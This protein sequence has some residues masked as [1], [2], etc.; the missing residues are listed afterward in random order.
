MHSVHLPFLCVCVGG[1]GGGGLFLGGERG[2]GGGGGGGGLG[3][4]SVPRGGFFRGGGGCSFFIKSKLKSEIFNDK[5]TF[6]L[7]CN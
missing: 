3:R 2:G 5:K 1:G 7:F 4:I 6:F